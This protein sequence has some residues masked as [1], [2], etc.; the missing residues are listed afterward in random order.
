MADDA[1]KTRR[2]KLLD[3]LKEAN[4]AFF[5]REMKRITV[6]ETFLKDVLKARSSSTALV[7]A[8]AEASKVLLVQDIETFLAG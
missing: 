1:T 2:D 4:D 8:N 5:E 3:D 7:K 6:E